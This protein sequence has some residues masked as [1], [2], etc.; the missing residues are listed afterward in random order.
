MATDPRESERRVHPEVTAATS[1]HIGPASSGPGAARTATHHFD[2]GQT[3]AGRFRIV[4]VLG[5]GGMGE[6]YRADDLTLGSSVALKFLPTDLASDP[7]RLERFRAEVRLTRQI[8]HANACRV[9][10]IVEGDGRVF[11]TMEYIDGEDLGSLLRRIGRLPQ[12]KGVEIARQ[13]CAGLQ[14]AHDQGVVHR[15]LKPANVMLDGRGRARIM[16]FGIAALG[17][18][19][20]E[21]AVAG[22]PLYMAPEQLSG[23]EATARSDLYALGLVLHE[24]FSGRRV[25]DVETLAQL[26]DLHRTSTARTSLSRYVSDIDPAIERAIERCLEHDPADR[27]VSAM[28]VAA[29]LPG[30]DPLAAAIA[31]G[32]TPSPALVAAAGSRGGLHPGGAIALIALAAACILGLVWLN[33]RTDLIAAVNPPMP[34][35]V[36][37]QKAREVVAAFEDPSALTDGEFDPAAEAGGWVVIQD[38]LAWLKQRD[39]TPTRWAG[40]GQTWGGPLTFWYRA[41]N[42]KLQP[43]G[44]TFIVEEDNPPRT[45]FGERYVR[46][47][48]RGRLTW[49]EIG[50][51]DWHRPVP[52]P[53]AEPDMAEFEAAMRFA[54]LDPALFRPHDAR[55]SSRVELDHFRSFIGPMPGG[56]EGEEIAV[57]GGFRGADLKWFRAEFPW[58]IG[59]DGAPSGDDFPEWAQ[60]LVTG[61]IWLIMGGAAIVGW[62]NIRARRS[63][64]RAAVRV[65]IGILVLWMIGAMLMPDALPGVD[66]VFFGSSPIIGNAIINAAYFLVF[67]IALEPTA[68]RV[69]PSL[70]VSWIRFTSGRWR[71]PMVGRDVLIGL[72]GGA[73]LVLLTRIGILAPMLF[74][75]APQDPHWLRMFTLG[76]PRQVLGFTLWTPALGIITA[77]TF[78]LVLVLLRVILRSRLAAVAGVW[79]FFAG[80]TGAAALVSHWSAAAIA[81]LA[82]TIQIALLLRFGFLPLAVAAMAGTLAALVPIGP[83]SHPWWSGNAAIPAVL[84]GALAVYGYLAAVGDRPAPASRAAF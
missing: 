70:L 61:L 12:D 82:A 19:T 31:A 69:W 7:V 15:D 44:S 38:Y 79:L 20:G 83:G 2:P 21:S 18:V 52:A 14:A 48:P 63:D 5:R 53:D 46:L 34:R 28:V 54:G 56:K 47:D 36:L 6:V 50:Q 73:L 42:E 17:E 51:A 24:I 40:V 45:N 65:A 16:D 29:S 43:I 80:A 25:H 58:S 23:R 62:R 71:D 26:R 66:R 11:L 49:M 33:P 64:V 67:Y 37:E 57:H 77:S 30:G 60:W 78:T 68:R 22:T 8:S 41:A 1:D 4:S 55:L 76:G 84:I 32:E 59:K 74:D 72:A 3:I 10:D 81:A 75:A 35:A 27:P 13:I 9:Y 39:A